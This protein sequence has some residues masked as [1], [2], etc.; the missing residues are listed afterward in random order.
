VAF[1]RC[2]L[3]VADRHCATGS[4]GICRAATGLRD[5]R[6]GPPGTAL[7]W[8]HPRFT[9]AALSERVQES[10]F[11]DSAQFGQWRGPAGTAGGD[12]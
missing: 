4:K 5:T 7:C 10:H 8:P 2:H 9:G 6:A 3:T 1:Y 12:R 11:R